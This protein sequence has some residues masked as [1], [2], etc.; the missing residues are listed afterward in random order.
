MFDTRHQSQTV[1]HLSHKD[2]KI[3]TNMYEYVRINKTKR[4]KITKI[5]SIKH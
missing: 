1:K 4:T 2:S 5:I 3:Y